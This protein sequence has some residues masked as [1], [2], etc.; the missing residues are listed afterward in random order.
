MSATPTPF[1]STL[2]IGPCRTNCYIFPAGDTVV[3]VDPGG[4]ESVLLD[5]VRDVAAKSTP[6]CTTVNILL[7]HTHADHFFGADAL[8]EA[9]PGSTLFC[10]ELDKPGLSDPRLNVSSLFGVNFA[11]KAID[12]VV[13]V[14]D[15]EALQFGP[16][17]VE[18]VGVPGHTRGGLAY[19]LRHEKVVFSGDTLFR[20]TIGR[21]DCPGGNYRVLM[22]AIKTKLC[23]LPQDFA[24][25]PGHD[26]PTTVG[27][28]KDRF[29][30]YPVHHLFGFGINTLP[31]RSL[32][33][34]RMRDTGPGTRPGWERDA[35][36]SVPS[37]ST[38]PELGGPA[39]R[40][41]RGETLPALRGCFGGC[42][43]RTGSRG[44]VR[45]TYSS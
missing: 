2:V 1:F 3:V 4:T 33:A 6:P 20:G 43:T 9:F 21:S 13:T 29:A 37:R 10:S 27:D 16:Y 24:V 34:G 17:D 18:A 15:G 8:L 30:I 14:E 42:G 41:P 32:S 25:Y 35:A 44:R 31:G 39:I 45:L 36:G 5:T 12:S 28:E 23:T 26:R 19:I 40:C 38:D 22:S 11:L 7:T